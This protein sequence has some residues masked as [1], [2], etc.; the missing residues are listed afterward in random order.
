[1]SP[2]YQKAIQR[3]PA[4]IFAFP[5]KGWIGVAPCEGVKK[6]KPF[7]LLLSDMVTFS[8]DA[9]MLVTLPHAERNPDK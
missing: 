4:W 1:M 2:L 5:M 9:T 7:G 6:G 3:G 8:V